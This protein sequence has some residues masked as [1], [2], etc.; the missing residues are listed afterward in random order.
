LQVFGNVRAPCA[1]TAVSRQLH[2]QGDLR[3]LEEHSLCCTCSKTRVFEGL[4]RRT[5]YEH[6]CRSFNVRSANIPGVCFT[7]WLADGIDK[8][9]SE[10]TISIGTS[11]SRGCY[12][13][14]GDRLVRQQSRDRR[15][16]IRRPRIWR[17]LTVCRSRLICRKQPYPTPHYT[18][19]WVSNKLT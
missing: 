3:I 7:T 2:S 9:T 11:C 6:P 12:L 13:T 17:E 19:F 10:R 8:Q 16:R 15:I 5:A 14:R 1:Y 4:A 18:A